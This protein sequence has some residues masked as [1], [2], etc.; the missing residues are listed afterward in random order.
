LIVTTAADA[1]PP[2]PETK[3]PFTGK[4]WHDPSLILA[5]GVDSR[6]DSDLIVLNP[7]AVALSPPPS[8]RPNPVEG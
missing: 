2:R 7:G 5:R 6:A 1:Q 8:L 3:M 4:I